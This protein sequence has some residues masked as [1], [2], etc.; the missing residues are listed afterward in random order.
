MPHI[1]AEEDIGNVLAINLRQRQGS[2]LDFVTFVEHDGHTDVV[3]DAA[4]LVS[5]QQ[6]T[7]ILE[8]FD[9]NS[10]GDMATLKTD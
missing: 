2:E 6:Y 9:S 3:F 8:S 5:G 4:N 10:N 1:Y 7:L